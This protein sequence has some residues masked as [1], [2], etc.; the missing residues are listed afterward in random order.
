MAPELSQN[1]IQHLIEIG[2]SGRFE[3]GEK[4]PSLFPS[5]RSGS[6]MRLAPHSWYAVAASLDDSQLIA[7]IKALTVLERL[8]NFSAG[9]VSPVIWLFRKLSERSHD[10][11]TPVIDWVLAHTDNPYLPFGS[12]NLGAQ[13][14]EEL[15]ALSARAAERAEARHTAEEN[16]QH[17]A[18]VRKAAEATHKLF[19]ALRRHD[20]KAVVALLSQGADIYASNEQG[21]SAF[22]YARSLGLQHLMTPSPNPAVHTDAAR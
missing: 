22:E 15:H 1:L 5:A 7:C 18:K 6:F 17:E 11:L 13:S 14:L 21:Q 2:A 10:D 9:S 8:P 12:H 3:Y 20:E 16:R 4:I 19:G